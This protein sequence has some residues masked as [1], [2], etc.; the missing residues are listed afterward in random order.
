M[1]RYACGPSSVLALIT[2]LTAAGIPTA[3]AYGAEHDFVVAPAQVALTGDF[4][5]VQLLVTEAGVT[6][7]R[8]KDLTADATFRS[9]NEAIVRLSAAGRLLAIGNGTATIAVTVDGVNRDV[10]VQVSGVTPLP[11][12]GY[13]E[14]VVPILSKAGCNAGACHASQYG[15][16]GLKLSVFNFEPDKDHEGIV[17]DREARRVNF[18]DPDRSLFLLKPTL[19]VPHG[20]SRRLTKGSIDYDMLKAWIASGAAGPKKDDAKVSSIEVHPKRRVGVSGYRQQLRVV[21][22]YSDGRT[23]DVT[24]WAQFDSMDDSIVTVTRDGLTTMVGRGQAPVIVRYCGQAEIAML[25]APYTTSV[26]LPG[27]KNNNFVDELAA[28][29]FRELGIEPSLLCDDATFLRRAYQDAIG[30]LP[31]A[32]AARAFLESKDPHKRD[33]LVESLLDMTGD[34]KLD[35]HGNAWAAYWALKWS[36]LIR[37]SSDSLGDQGM[38][39]MYNWIRESMRSNKPFDQFVRELVTAQG[40][41]YMSGPANY[42]RIA[43]NPAD[44]AESTAQIF[45]GIRLQCAKCH[46]HPFEKYGQEDYYGLAAFFARVGTKNSQEFGLFGRE[47]VVLVKSDGEVRHPRTNQVMP[48]TPLEGK[49][50]EDP[51]DRRRPL[52][53]W[54]TSSDNRFFA[55]NVVNRYMSYLMGTGLVEPVDDL[56]ATNPPSNPELMDALCAHFVKSKYN[57]KELV[58]VIMCS[59]LYQLD[60]QPTEANQSDRRFYSHYEVKR[61]AAE[62][63][64]D[65]IDFAAGTQTKFKDLPL[66][67]R[68]IALPD[69]NYPDYFLKTFGKP[70]RV[71]TCECERVP[72][73]NLAQTLHVLN[74]DLLSNKISEASGRVAKLLKDKQPHEEMVAELYLASLSRF[75]NEKEREAC[76]QM[77]ATAPT[78][79]EFYEDLLWALVNSKEFLFVR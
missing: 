54:L 74:G 26:Q 71:I 79:K 44:L 64:L 7:D 66:G 65:A 3:P 41:V 57:V 42:Y 11:K 16:G 4:D 37:S 34:P 72:D 45:L 2:V 1:S 78:P 69:S 24:A 68:A 48:P 36:D 60:S 35:V 43:N 5:Q 29:K 25:V 31:T 61:I 55:Q 21:A 18:I 15:K 23:R 40:S 13:T 10:P 75:P 19:D 28:N 76:R 46:H 56:R 33:R 17:R 39:A 27:W 67:T 14:H 22:H 20:G 32:E 47:S 58:R 63:L 70:R 73:P 38:W 52:A 8:A 12:L 30:T 51:L 77:L 9:S 49:S 62:P 53:V 6:E 59:R 50:L